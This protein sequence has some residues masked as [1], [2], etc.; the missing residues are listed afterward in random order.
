MN[1][2]TTLLRLRTSNHKLPIDKGKWNKIP[3]DQ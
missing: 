2:I 1:T 3:G